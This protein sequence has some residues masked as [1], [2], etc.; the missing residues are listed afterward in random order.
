MLVIGEPKVV[1]YQA[2]N[3]LNGHRYIGVTKQGLHRRTYGHLKDART[4][5]GNRFHNAIRKY[6]EEH[7]IFGIIHDFRDDY[8]LARVYEHEFI[9]KEKPEYNLTWGGEGGS[10]HQ[11]TKDK[12]RAIN[13]GRKA[14][15]E[16]R[17]KM[18]ASQTGRP[19]TK[20][21]TGQ[22]RSAEE[23]EKIRQSLKAVTW[24]DTPARIASRARTGAS[25]ASEARKIPVKCLDD[26]NVFE[27]VRAAAKFYG[28]DSV[29]LSA[30]VRKQRVVFK[31]KRFVCLPKTS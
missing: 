6:G 1:V 4:G 5:K 30:A 22:P 11:S 13:L 25:A 19:P 29:Q 10:L 15:A 12:L 26:G 16:T 21:R 14:S 7:F 24:V 20:G 8:D 2:R 18:A 31:G 27:S 3:L 28:L 9:C 17:A 23:R